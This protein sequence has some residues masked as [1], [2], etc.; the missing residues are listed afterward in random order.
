MTVDDPDKLVPV[1][2]SIVSPEQFDRAYEEY[3]RFGPE[4]RIPIEERWPAAIPDVDRSKYAVLKAQC[5]DIQLTASHWAEDLRCG[6]IAGDRDE[7]LKRMIATRY[8]FLTQR[9]RIQTWSFAWF[10]TR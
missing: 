2:L 4:G 8:P 3:G 6:R 10:V 5:H 7:V 9:D 1:E